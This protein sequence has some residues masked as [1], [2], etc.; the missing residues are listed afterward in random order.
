VRRTRGQVRLDSRSSAAGL[1]T[2]ICN[3]E[4]GQVLETRVLGLTVRARCSGSKTS[5]LVGEV[6]LGALEAFLAT[7][8]DLQV[9]PH[10][11]AFEIALKEEEKLDKPRFE[12]NLDQMRGEFVW[13]AN[14]SPAAFEYQE[15]T[16][17]SLM[18]LTGMILT[19]TSH[20]ADLQSAFE[21]LYDDELAPDRIT[22]I[23]VA[24]NS[25]HRLMG[26]PLSRLSDYIG[27]REQ[28]YPVR[29]RPQLLRTD[30]LR[31]QADVHQ[32]RKPTHR[33]ALVSSV[34][35]V[36]TWNRAGW[37][38]TGFFL[39]EASSLPVFALLFAN[40]EAAMHIFNRWR[41]RFGAQDRDETIY[42]SV[43]RA[44]SAAYPSHYEV[45]VTSNSSAATEE[46]ANKLVAYTGR[47]LTVTADTSRNLDLFSK[48][49]QSAGEYLLAPAIVSESP[50]SPVTDVAILKRKFSMRSYHDI[51]PQDI[52]A[53][54][55]PEKAGKR[56]E[57]S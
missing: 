37:Q 50:V 32:R 44:V 21:Q 33:T 25:Y 28:V 22:T 1:C 24:P 46:H 43:I 26:R 2:L 30:Q 8:P 35:D 6:V 10:T 36:H 3:S 13:P 17:R 5:I 55:F 45:L 51:G 27:S 57:D 4:Q 38:G 54:A 34:I 48:A 16:V 41:K 14:T 39:Y 52:E 19:S 56:P 23:T 11:E 29:K 40:R 20:C 49:F 42:L 31:Q 7:A 18:E 12:V 9:I 53:M 15:T 47:H